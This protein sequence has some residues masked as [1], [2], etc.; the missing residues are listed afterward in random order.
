MSL[1]CY[2]DFKNFDYDIF[3][4]QMII[5]QISVI[6]DHSFFGGTCSG[7]SPP[8]LKNN[9]TNRKHKKKKLLAFR[10]ENR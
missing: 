2:K 3:D 7:R 1:S 5:S 4:I 8:D 9:P 6:A 10:K